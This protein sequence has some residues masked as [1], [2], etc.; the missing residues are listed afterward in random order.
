MIKTKD[1]TACVQEALSQFPSRVGQQLKTDRE[2]AELFNVEYWRVRYSLRQLEKRGVLSRRQGSGTFLR[3]VSKPVEQAGVIEAL[4][5]DPEALFKKDSEHDE[6]G[7]R[8]VHTRL[9]VALW[10]NFQISASKTNN[11]MYSGL[12]R[13]LSGQGHSVQLLPI[14]DE[15]GHALK[16]GRIR[17][18][19]AENPVDGHLVVGGWRDFFEAAM[20]SRSCPA[21]YF[22]AG[23]QRQCQ[24]SAIMNNTESAVMYA[25]DQFA[26]DRFERI[27]FFGLFQPNVHYESM[28]Y[29]YLMQN[30]GLT[31]RAVELFSADTLS[32]LA[33]CV[34]AAGRLLDQSDRP[35]AVYVADDSLVVAFTYALKER[36]LVPGRDIAIIC[37]SNRGCD[38]PEAHQ[39]SRLEFNP[40]LVGEMAAEKLVNS[41]LNGKYPFE[42]IRLDPMWIAG[43]THT[44]SR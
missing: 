33:G 24:H 19:I 12:S 23:S 26:H 39:W 18:M 9:T 11:L 3:R 17:E 10:S 31:Y 36:N 16:P 38:L 29:D 35:E 28:L 44:M 20:P 21:V 40:E 22:G 14:Q 32:D 15:T 2:L 5:L 27:G 30:R 4:P 1:L 6:L 8:T 37:L 25:V 41:V 43:E 42:A 34:Q 7:G 13:V